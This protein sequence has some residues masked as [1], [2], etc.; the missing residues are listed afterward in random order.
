MAQELKQ[1]P[2]A[3]RNLATMAKRLGVTVPAAWP[4]GISP[5]M[6]A[7]AACQ[8][9]VAEEACTEFLA[10]GPIPSNCRRSSAPTR[11]NS[12]A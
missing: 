7:Y 12:P 11:P 2:D 3:A 6:Q 8:R 1:K 5:L 4:S 9:C 10:R